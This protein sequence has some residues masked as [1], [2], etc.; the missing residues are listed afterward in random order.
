[1]VILRAAG[2]FQ[3]KKEAGQNPDDVIDLLFHTRRSRSAAR[4]FQI[5]FRGEG[6]RVTSRR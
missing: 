2:R 3:K 1:L 4:L 6:G 5:W